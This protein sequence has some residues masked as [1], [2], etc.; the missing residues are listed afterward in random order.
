MNSQKMFISLMVIYLLF[1]SGCTQMKNADETIAAIP[2]VLT[3]TAAITPAKE[4]TP[5]PISTS[6]KPVFPTPTGR[7]IAT[8]TALITSVPGES[9]TRILLWHSLNELQ[10]RAL[11]EV[12]T[13]FQE[14]YPGIRVEEAYFPY[15][16]L[17]NKFEQV[18]RLGAGPSILLASQEWIPELFNAGLIENLNGQV[19]ERLLGSL[20]PVGLVGVNYKSALPALP[21]RLDGMILFRNKSLIAEPTH[22]LGEFIDQTVAVTEGGRIGAYLDLGAYFSLPLLAA[23]GGQIMDED[24]KPA[25]DD[26]HGVC[27]LELLRSLQEA[28]LPWVISSQEDADLFK[29]GRVGMIIDEVS[30]AGEFAGAIGEDNLI[31]DPWPDTDQGHLS[32]FVRS[33]VVMMRSNLADEEREAS[34]AFIRFLLSPDAQELFAE[35]ESAGFIPSIAGVDLSDRLIGEAYQA[36]QKGTAFPLFSMNAYWNVMEGAIRV[37]LEKGAEADRILAQAKDEI[38]RIIEDTSSFYNLIGV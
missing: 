33:G 23:C 19:D 4:D 18:A 21:Y 38:L 17:R 9:H 30:K 31:I 12:I 37:A 27:W 26:P 35:P 13:A 22:T 15:D 10:R 8:S 32:G 14:S 25:F 1:V 16:D 34:W 5:Y 24:G 2:S 7:V 36:F 28:G 6:A 29:S 11:G 20:A 3:P